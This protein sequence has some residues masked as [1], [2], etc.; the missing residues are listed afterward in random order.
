MIHKSGLSISNHMTTKTLQKI[1]HKHFIVYP[2]QKY[3]I[4]EK[5]QKLKTLNRSMCPLEPHTKVAYR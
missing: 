3:I 2:A 1:T 4:Y 5:K